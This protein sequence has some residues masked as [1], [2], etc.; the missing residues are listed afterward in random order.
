M[1]IDSE[2]KSAGVAGGAERAVSDSEM[3]C[4]ALLDSMDDG[5]FVAQDFR[6][7]FANEALPALLGYTHGE[8]VGA[9]FSTVVAPEF[10]PLWN[11]RWRVDRGPEPPRV[12]E[13]QLIAKGGERI[14]VELRA[15][16]VQ[17]NGRPA[18]LGIFRDV[19]ERKR[20]TAE[21]ERHR[22]HLEELVAE[23]TEQL[24][25]ANRVVSE[26]AAQIEERERQIALLNVE[27]QRRTV[28]AE[29]ADRIKSAVLANMS[30]EIRT[31][32]NAITGLTHLMGRDTLSPR[33]AERLEKLSEATQQLLKIVND[34]LDPSKLEAGKLSLPAPA[35][36]VAESPGETADIDFA[37]RR[38]L[39]AEDHPVNREVATD[40]L[41]AVGL[42][43]E[44]ARNGAEAVRLAE[45]EVFDLVLMDVQMPVMG[46]LAAT[47]VIRAIAGYESVPILAMTGNAFA[48]DRAQCLAAGMNDHI[49]KPVEPDSLYQT[50]RK[51]L[52][53]A[54]PMPAARAP[55]RHLDLQLGLRYSRGRMGRYVDLLQKYLGSTL[56]DCRS[57]RASYAAGAY[58]D[59]Q[60][61]AHS[62]TGAAA[63]IGASLLQQ[64]AAELERAIVRRE[65][66]ATIE[67]TAAEVEA[68][69]GAVTAEI[70][71][72]V[73]ARCEE[74]PVAAAAARAGD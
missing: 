53:P 20:V 16:R 60:R 47:R 70:K 50:L 42:S 57:L 32:L 8:F 25:Q 62:L 13:V 39:L 51:W 4:R 30:H 3:Q 64:L 27:L 11:Q 49:A 38:V 14:W 17:F 31:P 26:R 61:V 65:P 45:G 67:R 5:V 71:R 29:D 33:Q 2:P 69:N 12:Y 54:A 72:I 56:A 15:S 73:A 43:V 41:A 23:R 24:R 36:P 46:G 66:L 1:S 10:L 34:M 9:S 6:F 59:A 21:L 7:V 18:V 74:A 28:E 44:L 55:T 58:A 37:G 52:Q 35:D 68:E 63:F 19:S 22:H 48:D 40:L